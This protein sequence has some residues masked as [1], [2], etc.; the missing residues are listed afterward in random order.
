MKNVKEWAIYKQYSNYDD[1]LVYIVQINWFAVFLDLSWLENSD[2]SKDVDI[3]TT[4]H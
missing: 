1:F 4:R 2:S 3:K